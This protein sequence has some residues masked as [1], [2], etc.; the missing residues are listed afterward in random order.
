M[1][2]GKDAR[3][4]VPTKQTDKEIYNHLGKFL[5]L[6]THTQIVE[7]FKCV[8]MAILEEIEKQKLI[9]LNTAGLGVVWLHIRMDTQPKYYHTQVYKEPDFLQ[10]G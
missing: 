5:R 3:L 7:T 4:V 8:G 10:K 1:N 6:A 9:W 2:I